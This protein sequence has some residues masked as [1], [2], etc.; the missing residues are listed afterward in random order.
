[1]PEPPI[2]PTYECS[3]CGK[4]YSHQLSFAK[5]V[6][7]HKIKKTTVSLQNV[8][9][10]T[11]ESLLNVKPKTTE[12]LPNVDIGST[13]S[14]Q[15]VEQKTT[16]SLLNDDKGLTESLQSVD[17]QNTESLQSVD[18]VSVDVWDLKNTDSLQKNEGSTSIGRPKRIPVRPKKFEN[19]I[20][21]FRMESG[22]SPYTCSTCGDQLRYFSQLV[23]LVL[24]TYLIGK[25]V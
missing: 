15:N 22:D 11:T 1:V 4:E 6:R 20:L 25:V 12:S 17:Q 19:S 13:A 18:T 10:K 9:Q 3:T 23:L 5:H 2:K 21:D 8:S 14:L 7:S 16:G 24:P